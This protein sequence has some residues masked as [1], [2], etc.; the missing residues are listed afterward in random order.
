MRIIVAKTG[1]G[2]CSSCG[3][4]E[5]PDVKV[6]NDLSSFLADEDV[7]CEMQGL[8]W[9]NVLALKEKNEKIELGPRIFIMNGYY[10]TQ[11][12]LEKID[13]YKMERLIDG[14]EIL[15]QEVKPE[16]IFTKEQLE[17]YEKHQK[18]RLAEMKKEEKLKKERKK[19]LLERKLKK[20]QELLERHNGH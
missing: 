15:L 19:K 9:R 14:S 2:E 13:K 12:N 8:G 6:Y 10:S 17:Q 7:D 5:E 1:Y 11:V 16:S 3:G 4:G 18:T 20:A